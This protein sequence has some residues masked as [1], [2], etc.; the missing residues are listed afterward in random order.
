M[1]QDYT[2]LPYI[3]SNVVAVFIVVSAITW[4]TVARVMLSAIFIGAFG[5]NLFTAITDP[6]AYLEFGYLTTNELYRSTIFG[7]FSRHI[8]FY[9]CLIAAGQLFIG[10][11]IA[12]KGRLMS[13]AMTGG[14]LFL[15]AI[16]PLG[17]G[18]AFPATAIMALAFVILMYKK[19]TFSIY[20]II[21]LK[22]PFPDNNMKAKKVQRIRNRMF[23]KG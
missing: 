16:S 11:F 20:D 23:N 1:E 18:A 13:I 14:L 8:Q 19:T 9:V 6:T 22:R 3:I 2:S 17:Y 21:Y 12:F 10:V 4:V 7:S 15:L 5:L